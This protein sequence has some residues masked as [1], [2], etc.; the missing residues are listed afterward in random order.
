MTEADMLKRWHDDVNYI[1][2]KKNEA[3][4]K[5]RYQRDPLCPTDESKIQYWVLDDQSLTFTNMTE[6]EMF[7]EATVELETA[8]AVKLTMG[9][10]AA[11]SMSNMQ[12]GGFSS[13]ELGRITDGVQT[14]M[15]CAAPPAAVPKPDKKKKGDAVPKGD[16]VP[17]E[18]ENTVKV[19]TVFAQANA[20]LKKLSKDAGDARKTLIEITAMDA[21]E[22]LCL[23]IKSAAESLEGQYAAV[24]TFMKGESHDDPA[25]WLTYAVQS[26][27]I[28]DYYQEKK[29]YANAL[30]G[31]Q[32]RQEAHAV[33]I[34]HHHL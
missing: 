5:N 23:Q 6:M 25:M 31:V 1:T 8:D 17:K 14:G 16:T 18:G 21:S 19:V 7:M 12:V 30:G 4:V 10:N 34:G 24:Q 15:Q 9:D 33:C 29:Q 3:V 28:L 32:R 22:T 27:S 26:N 2:L 20:M 11:F 13:A